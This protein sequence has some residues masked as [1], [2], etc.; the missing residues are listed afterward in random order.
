MKPILLLF[1][2][3]GVLVD[4]ADLHYEALNAALEDCGH[5]SIQRA[6]HVQHFNGLPTRKKLSLLGIKDDR[7]EPLKQQYT[8]TLLADLIKPDP[9]KVA[10]LWEASRAGCTICVCSNSIRRSC[11]EMLTYSGLLS[12]VDQVFSNEDVEHPKPSPEVYLTAMDAMYCTREETVIFEDSVPGLQ[13]ARAS[14]A[15]VIEVSYE[16]MNT[17]LLKKE[18][19]V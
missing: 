4:A 3:D 1:D 16:T 2:L 15:R 18:R 12:Y 17:D 10:M 14:G 19:I 9:V 11:L 7:V 5:P 6:E 8:Q 13:S